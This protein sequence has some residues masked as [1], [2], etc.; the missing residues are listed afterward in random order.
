V[1]WDNYS[2][3]IIYNLGAENVNNMDNPTFYTN[4]TSTQIANP[5]RDGYIF[6]G[7]TGYRA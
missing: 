4:N 7:W 1:L 5:T 3:N 2:Y 6:L